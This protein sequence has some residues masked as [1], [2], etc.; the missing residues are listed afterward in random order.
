ML[1]FIAIFSV[2][3]RG[4]VSS[5]IYIEVMVFYI[6][7]SSKNN[8]SLLT[9]LLASDCIQASK[10]PCRTQNFL[11]FFICVSAGFS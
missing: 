9:I 7:L 6:M 3:L 10:A 2:L 4:L 5:T 8:K 11:I 1:Q